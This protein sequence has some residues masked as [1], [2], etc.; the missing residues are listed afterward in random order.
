[1]S[2]NKI[3]TKKLGTRVADSARP[4]ISGKYHV[5]SG[6]EQKWS[7]VADG[8]IRATRV[9]DTQLS[10]IE[11]AKETARKIEGEVIIHKKTG[12]IDQRVSLAK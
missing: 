6:E 5:I 4:T 9:F 8:N 1:M 2:S 7:V 3:Y 11:Y 12:E 10:A